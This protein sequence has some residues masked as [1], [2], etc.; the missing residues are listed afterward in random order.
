MARIWAISGS[1]SSS[2]VVGMSFEVGAEGEAVVPFV[3]V[4]FGG[5]TS[6]LSAAGGGLLGLDVKE[7]EGSGRAFR[8]GDLVRAGG[9]GGSRAGERERVRFLGALDGG[10]L[11][12]VVN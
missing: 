11:S 8:G 6:I 9:L 5:W 3:G 7:V 1:E 10:G 2:V 12:S 4:G